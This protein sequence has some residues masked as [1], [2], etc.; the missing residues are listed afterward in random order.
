MREFSDG[1]GIMLTARTEEIDKIL[2]LTVG[3]DDYLTKP[4][5][6]REL[7]AR[8]KALLRRPRQV[9][10][11]L[12]TN[13]EPPDDTPAPQR[14]EDLTI[15]EAQHEVTLHGQTVECTAPEFALL[16]TLARPHRR[17]FT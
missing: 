4:F 3:A 7:A 15:D 12:H 16:L 13:V 11:A 9:A 5:S 10:T 17:V 8:V 6:P 1:Y 2:G 14:W